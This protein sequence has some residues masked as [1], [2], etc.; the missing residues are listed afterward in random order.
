MAAI[1]LVLS[2]CSCSGGI[3]SSGSSPTIS[4][5]SFVKVMVQL[6]YS[7]LL[8][9]SEYL[10][11]GEQERILEENDLVANDLRRFVEIHGVDVPLMASLWEEIDQRVNEAQALREP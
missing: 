2:L 8:N 5:E 1:V 7:A 11:E 4:S 3:P 6:R 9:S 10:P